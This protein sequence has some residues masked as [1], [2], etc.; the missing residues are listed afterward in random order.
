MCHHVVTFL[1]ALKLCYLYISLTSLHLLVNFA[2][3]NVKESI[4]PFSVL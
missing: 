1:L 2:L 4:C 3:M